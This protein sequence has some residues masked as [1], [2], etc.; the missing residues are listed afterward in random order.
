MKRLTPDFKTLADFRQQNSSAI[1]QACQ[2]FI[3]FCRHAQ[4]LDQ[5][6]VAIDG[7]KFKAS[8]SMSKTYNRKQLDALQKQ[9]NRK[10]DGYLNTLAQSEQNEDNSTQGDVEK[11][12]RQLQ[13]HKHKVDDL[14]K[15][16]DETNA[17]QVCETEPD[18]KRMRSGREGIVVG[19]N[20][21]TAV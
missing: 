4:L 11:A 10:I 12:L 9:L 3:P 20:V 19:Y 5:R 1:R 8:A 7:S 16:M 17:K 14:S 15:Y 21:Q 18:A 13:I 6:M 2:A